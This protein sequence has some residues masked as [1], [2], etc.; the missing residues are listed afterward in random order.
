MNP[1]PTTPEAD[2]LTTELSGRLTVQVILQD[3]VMLTSGSRS[4]HMIHSQYQYA[5]KKMVPAYCIVDIN[6]PI[7]ETPRCRVELV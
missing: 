6:S 2:A 3:L 4:L 1:Q 7:I 5:D